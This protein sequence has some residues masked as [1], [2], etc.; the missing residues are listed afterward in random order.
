MELAT[1]S[2]SFSFNDTIY[3][4][5]DAILMGFL[6]DPILTNISVGFYEKLFFDRFPKPYIHLRYE[7]DTFA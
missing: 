2:V 6:L 5:V 1:K 3:R 7:D 4:Q